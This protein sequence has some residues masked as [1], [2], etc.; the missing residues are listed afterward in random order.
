MKQETRSEWNERVIDVLTVKNVVVCATLILGA[1]VSTVG[2]GM[3]IEENLKWGKIMFFAGFLVMLWPLEVWWETKKVEKD[4]K[5]DK[6][7]EGERIL[8]SGKREKCNRRSA[9]DIV[10]N[11][12]LYLFALSIY[13][14]ISGVGVL[15]GSVVIGNA[16]YAGLEY[17]IA[18]TFRMV[19]GG[20][21]LSFPVMLT[22]LLIY[23]GTVGE[24]NK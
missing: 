20:M 23:L 17:E 3:W 14:A 13:V 2:L 4:E 16:F 12:I 8:S 18:H 9:K 5:I 21:L 7:E 15:I 19:A 22:I 24:D 11:V 1:A 10:E 6:I